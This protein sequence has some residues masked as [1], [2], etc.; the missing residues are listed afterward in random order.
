MGEIYVE[1]GQFHS[2]EADAKIAACSFGSFSA[3]SSAISITALSTEDDGNSPFFDFHFSSPFLNQSAGSTGTV[4]NT[5]MYRIGSISKI[6]TVY[7]MLVNYGW[8]HWDEAITD[9]LPELEDATNLSG[10]TSLTSVD[11]NKITIGDLASQLSGIGRDYSYGDV[12]TLDIPWTE[13][14]LPPLPSEDIPRCGGNSTTPPC[15]RDEYFHGLLQRAP[16]ILPRTTPIYSNTAFRILGYILGAISNVPFDQLLDSSVLRPLNL[17]T[18]SYVTPTEGAWVIPNGDSAWYQ[19]TGD[20]TPTAGMYS[21][22]SD[23][24]KFGRDIL[25]SKQLSTLETRRWMKPTSHTSSL[26]F[27][28]GSPWEIFR[29]KSQISHGRTIDLYTK[30]GSLGQYDSLLVISPD[31]G[32]ALSIMT[33][34]SSSSAAIEVVS[35][36]VLQTLIPALENQMLRQECDRLCGTYGSSDQRKNSSLT[37]SVDTNGVQIEHW[38]NHGVDFLETIQAYSSQSGGPP[39]QRV[40]LQATNLESTSDGQCQDDDGSR[41]VKYHAIFDSSTDEPARPPR[42]MDQSANHWSSIDTPMYG[43]IAFDDFILHFDHAGN[44]VAIEP[45]VMRDTLL[46]ADREASNSSRFT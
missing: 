34:G 15:D 10:D 7:T 27:S 2:F 39:I 11:W 46:K 12:A 40:L 31:Y 28:V 3:N 1:K 24:A 26:S 36:M 17:T 8:E 41:R 9:Y 23:L 33:A 20:E 4:D 22:S 37:L 44:A 35:E 25:L 21:S 45:R 14:G 18:T 43:E 32:V 19:N 13:A 38:I 16:V 29:A 5:S 6:F 42:I 30:S